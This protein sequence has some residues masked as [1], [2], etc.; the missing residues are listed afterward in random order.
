M[1]LKGW[2]REW[3]NVRKREGELIL[4]YK[5]SSV[6]L[7]FCKH[8]FSVI[9]TRAHTDTHTHFTRS[10]ECKS[11]IKREWTLSQK[12]C[13]GLSPISLSH[14]NWS[15]DHWG[16]TVLT[17]RKITTNARKSVE[18]KQICGW[19]NQSNLKICHNQAFRSYKT[20]CSAFLHRLS[21]ISKHSPHLLSLYFPALR[22]FWTGHLRHWEVKCH[23]SHTTNWWLLFLFNRREGHWIK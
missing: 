8:S 16:Q 7:R 3:R 20:H 1:W 4:V 18:H 15:A 17:Y 9:H 11:T 21:K 10:Y 23:L 5:V 19:V 22:A 13:L 14:H 2:R 12:R 6:H